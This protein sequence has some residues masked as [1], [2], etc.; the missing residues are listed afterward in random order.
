MFKKEVAVVVAMSSSIFGGLVC[1]F[2]YLFVYST[3]PPHPDFVMKC[4]RE[5]K[6]SLVVFK[7]FSCLIPYILPVGSWFARNGGGRTSGRTPESLEERLGWA[8]WRA[9]SSLPWASPRLPWALPHSWLEWA[10]NSP[11]SIPSSSCVPPSTKP[12]SCI[13]YSGVTV[14]VFSPH[15]AKCFEALKT[16]KRLGAWLFEGTVTSI[17]RMFCFSL[18]P[19]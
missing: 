10:L 5:Q 3:A 6:S 12:P 2:I 15:L 7:R 19:V 4:V 11:A 9:D 8:G 14:L 18:E 16:G 17:C 13:L 1:S